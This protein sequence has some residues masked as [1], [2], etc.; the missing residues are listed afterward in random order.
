MDCMQISAHHSYAATPGQVL[1][2]MADERW[3]L[4]VAR[5][6]GATDCSAQV[7]ETGSRV[8]ASMPAPVRA[9]RFT[10]P[11][12]RVGLTIV[13]SPLTSE[14]TSTGHLDV[15]T[16]GMPATMS[17]TGRLMPD[18]SRSIVEYIAEFTVNVP[19]LG[20]T[21]EQAAAPYVRRVIDIQQV[22]GNDYFAGKLDD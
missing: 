18:N 11:N 8:W 17:G 22:V 7:D 6:A 19:L 14:G 15:D 5:R 21:L 16:P 13:W 4:E 1:A 2:M 3:L 12:M 10:G 9:E 20:K